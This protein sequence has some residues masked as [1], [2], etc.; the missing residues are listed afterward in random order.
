MYKFWFI[1]FVEYFIVIKMNELVLLI[2]IKFKNKVEWKKGSDIVIM[3]GYIVRRYLCK[4]LKFKKKGYIIYIFNCL[5]KSIKYVR[6]CYSS[7]GRM[8]VFGKEME[9]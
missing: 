6:K 9:E 4:F 7:I 1:F 2:W 8:V 5:L 3:E